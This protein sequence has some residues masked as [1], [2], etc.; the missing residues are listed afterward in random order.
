MSFL[1]YSERS[2]LPVL[3][4]THHGF[5]SSTIHAFSHINYNFCMSLSRARIPI[6]LNFHL[7]IYIEINLLKMGK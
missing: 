3:Y 1:F 4:E 2:S 6:K 7:C 5:A